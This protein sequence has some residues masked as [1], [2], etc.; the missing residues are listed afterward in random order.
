[1]AIER[2]S[3]DT[4]PALA[5]GRRWQPFT[6]GIEVYT[7]DP[8]PP[9]GEPFTGGYDGSAFAEGRWRVYVGEGAEPEAEGW[10]DGRDG[11]ERMAAAKREVE[12]WWGGA[13]AAGREPGK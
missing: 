2:D 10:C 5:P 3:D 13:L 4:V 6:T 7:R 12:R 9:P 11:E 1:M 8:A